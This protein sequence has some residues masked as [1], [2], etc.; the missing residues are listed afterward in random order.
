MSSILKVSEIQDPTNGN[1]A[2]TV[3][4]SGRVLTPQR[5]HFY[6]SA[7]EGN[8]DVTAESRF[9]VTIQD[10]RRSTGDEATCDEQVHSRYR[11]GEQI[12]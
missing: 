8:V 7:S 5:V 2:L 4:S 6:A 1:S 10:S 12:C 11:R 3:D 9:P